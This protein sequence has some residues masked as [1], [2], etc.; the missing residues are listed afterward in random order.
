MDGLGDVKGRMM[1]R[2]F[3]PPKWIVGDKVRLEGDLARRLSRVLR[4]SPGDRVV[5]LDNSGSE[6]E[7]ALASFGRDA[8]EAQVL[9]VRDGTGESGIQVTLYQGVMKGEKFDWVLQKCTEMGIS[10]FVPMICRR[11]VP[12]ERGTRPAARYAR[13]E[14]IVTEAAEQSGRSRL[15]E[16]WEHT[17]FQEACNGVAG[18]GTLS[19]IPW[20]QE[21]VT[22]LRPALSQLLP[23]PA[24]GEGQG[25]GVNIFIGPE[26]G[27]EESEVE[28]ARSC[29]VVPVSL[30][31]RV[32]RSESAG[33]AVVAAVMY[34]GGE[35]G[36]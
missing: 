26:G 35:L 12:Q 5:L 19:I 25:P 3:V 28:Y 32:L 21:A 17:A 22:G 7:V 8:V 18:A 29:G 4:L 11:S 6:Y 30:G 36:G 1:H 27:F 16:I 34:E 13:W 31:R 10:A 20:E 2:F 15:P 9:A 14:K 24:E 23:S 33:I